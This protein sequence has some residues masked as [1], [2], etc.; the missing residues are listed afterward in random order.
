[1]SERSTSTRADFDALWDY[2]DPAE[3]ERRFR[4]LL[5]GARERG[6]ASY[7]GQ[8]LTQIAR[9]QGLQHRFEDAHETLDDI[10][11]LSTHLPIVRIRYLLE[12]GRVFNSSGHP[13]TATP[14]FLAA[15]ELASEEGEEF[16]AV[17]AAHMLGIVGP[18]ERQLE[19]SLRALEIAERSD[20]PRTR[21]WCG[22]LYNNIGWTHHDLGDFPTALSYFQQG[23]ERRQEEGKPREAH[24]A[25]WTVARALR[26]LGRYDEALAMQ[27]ENLRTAET[28][29]E[30]DGF[31]HEEIGECLLALVRA[32]ESR[33]HFAR[34]HELLSSDPWLVTNEPERLERL[35]R[36]AKRA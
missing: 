4:A 30:P 6:D 20:D 2:H 10:D 3:S 19:W 22:S 29:G 14:L 11:D 25:A 32:H 31:I 16:H 21:G 12:R 23:L 15:W 7:L 34:A 18:S 35:E 1:M 27:E 28:A 13:A 26:S 8:L 5:P 33:S 36:L 9:T 24:I 17:D